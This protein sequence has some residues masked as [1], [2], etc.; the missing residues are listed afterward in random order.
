MCYVS[1]SR[2][3]LYFSSSS[4]KLMMEYISSSDGVWL[5]KNSVGSITAISS[6]LLGDIM[7]ME[8][9][10]QKATDQ[11]DTYTFKFK[12][13]DH[14]LCVQLKCEWQEREGSY[15]QDL[16]NTVQY[17]NRSVQYWVE[18]ASCEGSDVTTA[19]LI[20]AP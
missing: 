4:Q 3:N 15:T 16:I 17:T 12:A 6:K 9:P 2:N 13:V 14:Q 18:V 7:S 1:G 10:C 11:S 8:K 19:S 20:R 5:R